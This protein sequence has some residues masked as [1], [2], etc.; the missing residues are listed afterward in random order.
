MLYNLPL[1][2]ETPPSSPHPLQSQ[3]NSNS[4]P[5]QSCLK[6][7]PYSITSPD[8]LSH[9]LQSSFVF[10]ISGV[11]HSP[12]FSPPSPSFCLLCWVHLFSQPLNTVMSQGVGHLLFSVYTLFLGDFILSSNLE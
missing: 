6:D 10:Y 8:F 3:L 4:I 11:P 2:T 1:E 5:Q 9:L 7:Y 12:G